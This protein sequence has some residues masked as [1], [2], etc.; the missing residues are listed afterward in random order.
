MTVGATSVVSERED[1]P[2]QSDV[3]GGGLHL[4]ESPPEGP[5]EGS[6]Y[7]CLSSDPV[8]GMTAS[9]ARVRRRRRSTRSATTAPP[10][11]SAAA[12]A[13]IQMAAEPELSVATVGSE[14]G[15]AVV[16]GTVIVD[17]T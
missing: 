1:L 17:A 14:V 12:A 2:D 10:D 8:S 4:D 11:T 5:D 7:D 15:T 13:M 9:A 16:T 6:G 3:Q